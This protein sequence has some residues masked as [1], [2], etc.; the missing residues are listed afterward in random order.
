MWGMVRSVKC[1]V[2]RGERSKRVLLCVYTVCL[3]FIY[4][5][6][7]LLPAFHL[8]WGIQISCGYFRHSAEQALEHYSLENELTFVWLPF[9]IPS[10]SF[11]RIIRRPM[12]QQHTAEEAVAYDQFEN[13]LLKMLAFDPEQRITP[14]E[15]LRHPFFATRWVSSLMISQLGDLL[16]SNSSASSECLLSRDVM[17]YSPRLSDPFASP[18]QC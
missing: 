16:F 8:F 6:L 1:A 17:L 14:A 2:L 18:F 9:Q 4:P 5:F 12:P 13:L 3:A 11:K 10:R 7:V 15:A